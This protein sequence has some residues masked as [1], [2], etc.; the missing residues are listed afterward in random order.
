MVHMPVMILIMNQPETDEV[1]QFMCKKRA[2][3]KHY[4]CYMSAGSA[5]LLRMYYARVKKFLDNYYSEE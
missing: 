4:R 2:E 1:F 3:G 5:K